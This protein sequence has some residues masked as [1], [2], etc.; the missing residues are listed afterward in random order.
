MPVYAYQCHCGEVYEHDTME[1]ARK[2]PAC[3]DVRARKVPALSTFVL[4]GDGWAKDGYRSNGG[5]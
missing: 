3:G 2:C 4:V 1:G 5:K